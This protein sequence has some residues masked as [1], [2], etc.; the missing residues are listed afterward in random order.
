MTT[1]SGVKKFFEDNSSH[2]SA[3]KDPVGH[4]TNSGLLALVDYLS[5]EF[6]KINSRLDDLEHRIKRLKLSKSNA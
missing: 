6:S 1:R 3:K 2:I 4:N 5:S